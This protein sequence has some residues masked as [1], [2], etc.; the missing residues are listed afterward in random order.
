VD[1]V[2]HLN[3][4]CKY[5][6]V[7]NFS[8]FIQILLNRV[9]NDFLQQGYTSY[10]APPLPSFPRPTTPGDPST[11]RVDSS[12]V[13]KTIIYFVLKPESRLLNIH[14][15]I[16]FMLHASYSSQAPTSSPFGSHP[17]R[18]PLLRPMTFTRPMVRN[19]FAILTH[20][21][22]TFLKC[23]FTCLSGRLGITRRRAGIRLC[24][25]PLQPQPNGRIW[26][27][28]CRAVV[29]LHD[30]CVRNELVLLDDI[31][32]INCIVVNLFC[33]L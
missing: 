29:V 6:Q 28:R 4:T 27:K 8:N 9:L 31:C 11:P 7:C 23:T 30:I 22:F 16:F 2:H 19:Y 21:H 25:S 18:S 33:L 20:V 5:L 10:H 1:A 15:L 12:H 14:D 13:S 17:L 26:W 24:G 32:V 3:D